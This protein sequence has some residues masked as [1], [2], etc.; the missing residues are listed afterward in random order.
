VDGMSLYGGYFVP[1]GVDP[2][3]LFTAEVAPVVNRVVSPIVAAALKRYGANVA[4]QAGFSSQ[5]AMTASAARIATV[6][7]PM[8][9]FGLGGAIATTIILGIYADDIAESMQYAIAQHRMQRAN[10]EQERRRD[11]AALN[12]IKDGT[13]LDVGALQ[14]LVRRGLLTQEEAQQILEMWQRWS[15]LQNEQPRNIGKNRSCPISGEQVNQGTTAILKDGYYEVNGL[16]FTKYYYE[17]LWGIGGRPAPSLRAKAILENAPAP[18]PDPKGRDGF[19]R[20]VH[21]GWELIYNPTTKE[22]YHMQP[23]KVKK[24]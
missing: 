8:F 2:E 15:R 5:M 10:E 19:Y 22:V 16:R 18:M 1:N 3:G 4:V 24:K 17:K 11:Q 14:R 7:R 12:N 21:D 20:Y 9:S 13:I 23:I 6:I